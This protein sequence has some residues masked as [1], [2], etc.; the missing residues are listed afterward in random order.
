MSEGFYTLNSFIFLESNEKYGLN[1]CKNV[2]IPSKY[3]H[4]TLFKAA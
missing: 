2:Q 4:F 3:S 1:F